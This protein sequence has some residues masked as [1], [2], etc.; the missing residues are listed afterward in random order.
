MPHAIQKCY[1]G[2]MFFIMVSPVFLFY[3]RI[4]TMMNNLQFVVFVHYKNVMFET[5]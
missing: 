5:D 2:I 1:C 3:F 4:L